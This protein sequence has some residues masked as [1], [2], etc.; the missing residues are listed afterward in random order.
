MIDLRVLGPVRVLADDRDL[1]I[2]HARQRSLLAMLL[3]DVN[4]VVPRER[5]AEL[6]WDGRP[7]RQA[8]NTLAGYA[9]RLRKVLASSPGRP[10]L[11]SQGG[12]YV[13]RVDP[14][15][16]DLCRFRD[17]AGRAAD[18]GDDE[19]R[20]GLLR[21]A[22][23]QWSGAALSNLW[24]T[25]VESL[26]TTLDSERRSALLDYFDAQLRL[27]RPQEILTQLQ[28]L[29][30]ERPYDEELAL[31]LVQAHCDSGNPAAALRAYEA[32][33]ARLERELSTRP[34]EVLRAAGERLLHP[35]RPAGG[36]AARSVTARTHEQLRMP[37]PTGYFV[38]RESELRE[39]DA[40]LTPGRAALTV[41]APQSSNLAVISG[42]AGAGKTTLSLR[43]AQRTRDSFPDGQFFVAL[44]GHD[45]HLPPLEPAETLARVLL[46][47]GLPAADIPFRLDER[48]ALYRTLLV[49]RRVLIV[50]DD[51][52]DPEQV[53]HLLPPSVDGSA[54][55]VT[56]RNRMPGLTATYFAGEVL[57]DAL[58]DTSAL[59]LLASLVGS[60]RVAKEPE[61][62]AGIVR[63]SGR[64]P[65]T[66]RLSGAYAASHPDEPLG[67]V[68]ARVPTVDGTDARGA[69]GRALAL[70]Y[71]K[72]SEPERQL[73][74]QLGVVP[75]IEFGREAV[76]ALAGG[77]FA[78]L[79]DRLGALVR[80]NLLSEYA[81]RRYRMH[82]MVK[83]YA[84]GR[85][86]EEDPWE[87]H[88]DVLL[89]LLEWYRRSVEHV[90]L[91][92]GIQMARAHRGADGSSI[93]QEAVRTWPGAAPEGTGGDPY[94]A[95]LS[96]E[97]G[98]A[99]LDREKAGICAAIKLSAELGLGPASWRLA[100]AMLGFIRLH[101]GGDDWSAAVEAAQSAAAKSGNPRANTAMLLNMADSHYRK[102]R[103]S[104]ERQLAREAL[105]VS[106]DASWP[107]GEALALAVLGRS[108]WSVGA[109]GL[110][111]RY[112]GA[113]LRI[114]ESVGDLAGQANA[115]GRLARN[116]YDAGD[117]VSALRDFRSSLVL[118]ERAGSRFGQ[119]R[120]PAYIALSLRLLGRYKEA[121]HWCELAIRASREMDFH[122]GMAI[123]L[124]CRASLLSDLGEHTRAVT[125]A[126]EAHVAM[127]H[128]S[129]PRIEADCLIGLGGVEAAAEQ[130]DLAMRS[131]GQALLI[132]EEIHYW[133]GAARAQAESAA[134]YVRLGLYEEA[135]AAGRR[136]RRVLHRCGMRLVTAQT[137][138]S[139]AD[140]ALA[141]GRIAAAIAGHRRAAALYRAAGHP[142][143]EVRALLSW[144]RAAATATGH[145]RPTRP[146][147]RALHLADPLAIPE[148]ATLRTLL[149]T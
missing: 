62:A 66:V 37:D 72:L 11:S 78:V 118:A 88:R 143:G 51:A 147:R 53:R 48:A 20:C 126:R 70:S 127:P 96:G 123:A 107:A 71:G 32:V 94:D 58:D 131:F 116:A 15:A 27:G 141:A 101:P 91:A 13:L 77:S 4:N 29:T 119:I 124:T 41:T 65:L 95:D 139:E 59:A 36:R 42:M 18:V 16:V 74:R 97:A 146:W 137:L 76:A 102:G 33:R 25:R 109:T 3:V 75:G 130:T 149:T 125:T 84:M 24:G 44:R 140:C 144:G 1:D 106:R 103:H 89:R 81:P 47:L 136:A 100:D 61:A 112:L 54:V 55:V 17:L 35:V 34:G 60:A 73:F 145:G 2:G 142:L 99:W 10:V 14:A 8:R 132:S 67:E 133:Q 122:E 22:L 87:L 105:T 40:L 134:A 43:W 98:I 79:D 30:E 129:D 117:P 6:V 38:G 26:R 115:L 135:L 63:A 69:M 128:L 83:E 121:D 19:E 104:G 111:D 12:G 93:A 108:Y 31:R 57:L 21:S 9:T 49:G 85:A 56:C 46:A 138:A 120:L 28:T 52:A 5:L 114:H 7:P 50:L 39:L 110:A 148:A 90:S 86:A 23:A 45:R 82:H 113:A 68:L 92:N 80:A 64:L